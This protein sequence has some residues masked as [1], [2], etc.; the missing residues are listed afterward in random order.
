MDRKEGDDKK[1]KKKKNKTERDR[2]KQ[3]MMMMLGDSCIHKKLV[4]CRQYIFRERERGG[5]S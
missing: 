4:K 5:P 3:E 1:K 2:Q